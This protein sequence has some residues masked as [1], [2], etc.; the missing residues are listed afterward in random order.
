MMCFVSS[1]KHG[2]IYN[3]FRKAEFLSHCTYTSDV[4][5]A[6]ISNNMLY[7]VTKQALETY[8]VLSYAEVSKHMR[9]ARP[10]E[11]DDKLYVDNEENETTEIH[12]ENNQSEKNIFTHYGF[13]VYD[14]EILQKVIKHGWF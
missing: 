4:S 3:V 11:M 7:S 14:L 10:S 5:T 12:D 1:S 8:L 2:F 9:I 6:V 13:P